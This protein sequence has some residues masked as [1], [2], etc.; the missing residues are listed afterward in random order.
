M[1]AWKPAVL[2]VSVVALLVPASASADF[3]T[4]GSPLAETPNVTDGCESMPQIIDTQG[5]MGPVPSGTADCTWRQAG[6]FGALE[7][8]RGSTAPGT[9]RITT[10]SVRSGPNPSPLRFQIIRQLGSVCCFFVRET[11]PVTPAPNA[12]ST[13]NVDLPV[14]RNVDNSGIIAYD[15]IALAGVT[16]GGSLPL[17]S[18]GMTSIF[19]Q[20]T[21]GNPSAGFYYPR[22]GAI[23]NDAGGG[24]HEGGLPGI[25]VLMRWTWCGNVGTG[26]Q[27][28]T[29]GPND[30]CTIAVPNGGFACTRRCSALPI[31]V[32]V[33][34]AGRLTAQDARAAG[35]AT[36]AA[37]KKKKKKKATALISTVSANA[38][39]AGK[40][41]L[42]I[43]PTSAGRKAIA[44]A[45]GRKLKIS[46]R[47]TF[48]PTGAKAVT[49]TT[50]VTLRS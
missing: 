43:K 46:V 39:K 44:K 10:I 50:S 11:N 4:L 14:E 19:D 16:G 37:S 27:G 31:A 7:D 45:R 22:M 6:V 28:V 13:F 33:P 32:T 1:R 42:T 9:G 40:V 48:A 38:T 2:L 35:R 24:R 47:L 26:K 17:H 36:A 18:N 21:F 34:G 3:V 49:K 5:H 30:G 12:V 20:T 23:P 29:L 8:P 41:K 25:E 15:Q